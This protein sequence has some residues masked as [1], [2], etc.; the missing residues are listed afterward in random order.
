LVSPARKKRIIG[1]QQHI[2]A[3]FDKALGVEL[4]SRLSPAVHMTAD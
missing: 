4:A 1:D 3:L 2:G